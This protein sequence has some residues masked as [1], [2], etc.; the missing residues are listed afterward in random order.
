MINDLEYL[1][2]MSE[3]N[4]ILG[5]AYASTGGSTTAKLGT[6]S[7]SAYSIARG[8]RAIT[9]T[10]TTTKVSLSS[11]YTTTQS[12]AKATASASTDSSY[13]SSKYYSSSD[14][15]SFM[16]DSM[17]MNVEVQAQTIRNS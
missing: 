5:A 11:N 16:G 1:E 2:I 13:S 15:T 10:S 14:F 12:D 6:G 8:D 17:T 9:T 7:A 3:A 4:I